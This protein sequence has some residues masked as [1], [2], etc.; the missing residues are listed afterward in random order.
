MPGKYNRLNFQKKMNNLTALM[1][2]KVPGKPDIFGVGSRRPAVKITFP[3]L[4]KKA[5][6]DPRGLQA[7]VDQERH[8]GDTLDALIG[9]GSVGALTALA[10]SPDNF[11][12]RVIKG[13]MGGY[14]KAKIN[15]LI[16]RP[17]AVRKIFGHP[18]TTADLLLRV[19]AHSLPAAAAFNYALGGDDPD[20]KI[21]RLLVGGATTI[22]GM[23]LARRWLERHVKLGPQYGRQLS[24]ARLIGGLLGA[25]LPVVAG[26]LRDD[27]KEKLQELKKEGGV[28][29]G[30]VD[31]TA[32]KS[33]DKIYQELLEKYRRIR[34]TQAQQQQVVK[35]A[36]ASTFLRLG[37]VPEM[38]KHADIGDFAGNVV[39]GIGDVVGNVV[40]TGAS[41]LYGVPIRA[42]YGLAR[43]VVSG[44]KPLWGPVVDLVTPDNEPGLAESVG[45]VVDRAAGNRGFVEDAVD[46]VNR[47][48]VGSLGTDDQAEATTAGK[49]LTPGF[50]RHLTG[51]MESVAGNSAW[52]AMMPRKFMGFEIPVGAGHQEAPRVRTQAGHSPGGLPIPLFE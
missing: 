40:G 28:P 30:P 10:D 14:T 35:A 8:K 48:L 16:G 51:T 36:V 34:P 47:R 32:A 23:E 7:L 5:E 25:A 18:H 11:Y 12:N 39:E 31:T 42:A 21:N 15:T 24:A 44:T 17:S 19:G 45:S 1:R 3:Q 33:G 22:G 46:T 37:I 43:G 41:L 27:A 52:K 13:D 4:S 26:H 38:A 20:E 2:L 9:A 29:L 49:L 6:F 50:V